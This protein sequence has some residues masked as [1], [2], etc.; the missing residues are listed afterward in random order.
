MVEKEFCFLMSHERLYNGDDSCGE[1]IKNGGQTCWLIGLS[2]EKV[3]AP[4]E[5]HLAWDIRHPFYNETQMSVMFT[6]SVGAGIWDTQSME[7]KYK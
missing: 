6:L 1:F 4:I 5:T 3:Y 2:L 7:N